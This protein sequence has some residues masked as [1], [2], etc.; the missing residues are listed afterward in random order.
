M[1][2]VPKS[3]QP[4]AASAAPSNPGALDNKNGPSILKG[5]SSFKGMEGATGYALL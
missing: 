2:Y 3:R 4:G 1:A 5:K